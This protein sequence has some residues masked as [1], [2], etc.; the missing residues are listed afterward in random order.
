VGGSKVTLVFCFGP[1][2]K[3]CSFDLDLDQTEQNSPNQCKKEECDYT[4]RGFSLTI[5]HHKVHGL[6]RKC[7]EFQDP[8]NLQSGEFLG[9][10]MFISG[11]LVWGPLNFSIL[12]NFRALNLSNSESFRALKSSNLAVRM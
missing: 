1:E 8:K 5:Y 7:L 12:E 3:F 6:I 10:K 11:L 2:L 4:I 9:L